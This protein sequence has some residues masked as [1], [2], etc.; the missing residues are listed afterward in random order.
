M[1][2]IRI[3]SDS[4]DGMGLDIF[5]P[6][7]R[8]F[9]S[10]KMADRRNPWP[11]QPK[12]LQNSLGFCHGT[13]MKC[14]RFIW[15]TV[16]DCK[17][18]N[19]AARVTGNNLRKAISSSV[20]WQNTS[21][22]LEYFSRLVQGFLRSSILNKE[23]A[24][25]TRLDIFWNYTAAFYPNW[26][27]NILFQRTVYDVLPPVFGS[28][29]YVTDKEHFQTTTGTTHD[30]KAHGGTLSNAQFKKAPGSWKVHYVEDNIGKVNSWSFTIMKI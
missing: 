1:E 5:Q 27:F 7:P 20:M 11:R 29:D 12:W 26:P 17:K 19:R 3:S 14:L 28:P 13:T 18:T 21:Q 22:F 23:K 10:L 2:P 24:L 25:G 30:Y 8:A 16:S 9:S 6:H 15:R 4:L